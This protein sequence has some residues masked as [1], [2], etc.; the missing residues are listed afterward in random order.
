MIGNFIYL[1]NI[2]RIILILTLSLICAPF[3]GKHRSI[4]IF[5][6]LCGP[7]FI[8]LGQSLSIRSDIVGDDIAN[9]LSQ[10]QDRVRPFSSK[11]AHKIIKSE[12]KKSYDEIFT[13][14]SDF[15]V[16]SASI[17]QVY[18][19]RIGSKILAFKV[20][21]PN[22]SRIIKRDIGTIDLLSKLSSPFSKYYAEKLLDISNVLKFCARNEL[23]LLNEAANASQ[24]KDNLSDLDYIYIPKIYWDLSSKKVLTMEWIDGI[25]FSDKDAMQKSNFDKVGLS[26]K[27]VLSYLNQVYRDGFFHADMHP[28]NLFLMQDGGIALVDFGIV[29]IIDRKTRIAIAQILMSFI[30]KDYVLVAKLHIDAGIVPPDT[31]INKFALNCRIIGESVVG[32]SVKNIS[33]ANLL[34]KLL[35]MSREYNMKPN[36][37]L[38]LLQKTIMLVE[39]NGLSLNSDLNIWD[40]AKPWAINWSKDNIGIDI[41][42]RDQSSYFFK[43]VTNMADLLQ[44]SLEEGVNNNYLKTQLE[45]T[46]K[47]KSSWKFFALL[48]FIAWFISI[49]S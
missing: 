47:S 45:K 41:K 21:R 15:P 37:E 6:M 11:I 3:I 40:I 14:F 29:G 18:K 4:Y 7:S 39:G 38:L 5:L 30:K 44:K 34:A 27:L 10:F 31:D 24:I 35:S 26:H 42:M 1:V 16:A 20:L 17:A 13:E 43:R 9:K 36:P 8:K 28:G 23:N 32:K 12:L 22:I 48:F 33:F 49:F 19:C 25:A 46:N 2:I